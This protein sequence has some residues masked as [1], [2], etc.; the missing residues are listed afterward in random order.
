MVFSLPVQKYTPAGRRG[1]REHAAASG[2]IMV[3]I[4]KTFLHPQNRAYLPNS[5]EKDQIQIA[6]LPPNPVPSCN[7]C[8]C[9]IIYYG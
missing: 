3:L 6:A 8:P 2:I 5:I 1:A 7:K 4:H 9:S